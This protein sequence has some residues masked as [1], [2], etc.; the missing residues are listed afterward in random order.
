MAK[1]RRIN[2]ADVMSTFAVFLALGGVSYAAITLPKNSVAGKHIKKSAV[3]SSDVK[4]GS[5]ARSDF[6][7]GVL[8]SSLSGANGNDGRDGSDGSSG[9]DGSDG[10]DGTNGADG[11]D[12]VDGVDGATGPQ[13][14]AGPEGPAGPQGLKG[15]T[16]LMGPEGPAGPAG[17]ARAYATI[18]PATCSGT[19]TACSVTEAKDI[20]NVTRL[21]TGTYCLDAWSLS[22]EFL[23]AFVTVEHSTTTSP[24][25]SAFAFATANTVACPEPKFLVLTKRSSNSAA[26]DVGF[27][28]LIP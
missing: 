28:I 18:N 19:P 22:S 17:T 4:D 1:R 2:Y 13:G 27:S 14:P 11:V 9:S 26:N 6:K 3:A 10:S 5:L 21:S 16:G 12:G 7:A 20:G 8:P 15:N 23:P 24:Q 25:A